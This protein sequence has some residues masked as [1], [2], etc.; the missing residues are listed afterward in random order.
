MVDNP[1]VKQDDMLSYFNKVK[2]CSLGDKI[3]F[4]PRQKTQQD[5]CSIINRASCGLFP[6]RAEGYG[7]P[8]LEFLSC[9]KPII[10]TNY[11]AQTE[12]CNKD[13]SYLVDIDKF[14]TAYD[15]G[16]FKNDNRTNTGKWAKFEQNQINQ[17]VD[18]MRT[19]HKLKQENPN[20]DNPNGL[21]AAKKHSWENCAKIIKREMKR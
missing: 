6:T 2:A 16:F 9:S 14:E 12:F 15:G 8:I 11:S 19:V 3:E 1:F 13:N 18:H 10:T 17:F 7:L 5:V 21:I 20:L 4:I